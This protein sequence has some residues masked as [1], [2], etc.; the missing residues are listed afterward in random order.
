MTT[1]TRVEGS[2]TRA[3]LV[4]SLDL[5][6]PGVTMLLTGAGLP[7]SGTAPTWEAEISG[8]VL[9]TGAGCSV[10]TYLGARHLRTVG[11]ASGEGKA[12]LPATLTP[13]GLT[14]ADGYTV[15]VVGR[16]MAPTGYMWELGQH[17]LAAIGG[18]F[19]LEHAAQVSALASVANPA[20]PYCVVARCAGTSSRLQVGTSVSAGAGSI[21]ATPIPPYTPWVGRSNAYAG[22]TQIFV[23]AYWPRA[24]TDGE[25]VAVSTTM[26]GRFPWLT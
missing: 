14:S 1:Y 8:D 10:D 21:N 23:L 19:R 9:T 24:L 12:W 7:A 5:G 11:G 16:L 22:G 20:N 3:P 13:S 4:A 15:A 17:S 2:L 18:A 26:K 25:M 6:A